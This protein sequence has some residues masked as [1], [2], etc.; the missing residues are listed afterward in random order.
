MNK[1]QFS[2]ITERHL[3]RAIRMQAERKWEYPFSG[4]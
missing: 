3:G 4:L 2:D 1:V